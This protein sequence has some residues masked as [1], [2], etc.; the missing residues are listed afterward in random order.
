M[1][2]QD[3]TNSCTCQATSA[4]AVL[5]LTRTGRSVLSHVLAQMDN[6]KRFE[7]VCLLC[8]YETLKFTYLLFIQ[9]VFYFPL[10]PKLSALLKIKKYYKMCQHEDTRPRNADLIPRYYE[11]NMRL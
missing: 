4:K 5:T 3:V 10:K 6:R 9:R 8:M 11:Q 1:D 7:I 2:A